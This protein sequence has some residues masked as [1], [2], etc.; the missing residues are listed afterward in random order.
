[1]KI[2]PNLT[3]ALVEERFNAEQNPITKRNLGLVLQHMKAEAALDLDG[4]LDTL[5]DEPK[6]VLH[7]TD[8]LPEMNP[9][10]SHDAIRAF[11][12]LVIVQTGSHRFEFD[13]YR[14]V[15]DE[16][17]VITEGIMRM[18][19]PGATLLGMGVE[20]DDADAYYVTEYPSLYIW[21]ADAD[22]GKLIGED[23]YNGAD[24]FAGIADRKITL[25][26]I[27]PL[28]LVAS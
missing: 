20:V 23:I 9:Q 13:V 19:Y 14:V 18:V 25:D 28:E 11:Y 15:A 16:G 5:I 26:D 6:Y 24:A 27:A 1:M 8:G 17:T 2:N 22:K 21:K 10:G 12:D 3:W 4:I 7:G